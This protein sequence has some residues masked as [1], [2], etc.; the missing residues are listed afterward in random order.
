MKKAPG[1]P[2]AFFGVLGMFI[3][4]GVEVPSPT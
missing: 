3:S 4:F 1:H 2:G